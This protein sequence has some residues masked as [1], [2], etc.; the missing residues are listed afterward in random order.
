MTRRKWEQIAFPLAL[1]LLAGLAVL[2]FDVKD[3]DAVSVLTTVIFTVCLVPMTVWAVV[4]LYYAIRP[5]GWP[6]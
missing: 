4:Y 5:R 3:D 6:E 1:F 2:F